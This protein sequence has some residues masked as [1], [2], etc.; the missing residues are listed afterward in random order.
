MCEFLGPWL[1]DNLRIL[2]FGPSQV[3]MWGKH[4]IIFLVS[5]VEV[6]EFQCCELILVDVK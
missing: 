3:L 6:T 4:A 2:S 1:Q 5:K